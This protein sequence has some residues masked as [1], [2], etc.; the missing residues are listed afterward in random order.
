MYIYTL[1]LIYIYL[2]ICHIK[3]YHT[4]DIAHM[5]RRT[6]QPCRVAPAEVVDHIKAGDLTQRGDAS[7]TTTKLLPV[8]AYRA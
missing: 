2:I 1:Y 3:S 7:C 6:Q 8:I 4:T 5:T